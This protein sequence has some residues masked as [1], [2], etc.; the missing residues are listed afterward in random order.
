[1]YPLLPITGEPLL[2][3]PGQLVP[4]YPK[5]AKNQVLF[6]ETSAP[7]LYQIV[8]ACTLFSW[9][10]KPTRRSHPFVQIDGVQQERKERVM[11]LLPFCLTAFVRFVPFVERSLLQETAFPCT[12]Y[13][14]IDTPGPGLCA[15][16]YGASG[17]GR[18]FPA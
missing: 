7:P 18:I 11:P 5:K 9:Q 2:A 3:I 4:L 8:L 10:G 1:L 15:G 16:D 14:S 6:D 13:A 17:S 12:P